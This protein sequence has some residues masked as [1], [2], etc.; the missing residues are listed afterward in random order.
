MIVETASA[1]D[2]AAGAGL[3]LGFLA[4][5][6]AAEMLRRKTRLAPEWTRKLVHVAAGLACLAVPFLIESHWVVLWLALLLSGIFWSAHRTGRL[7]SLHGV[8]RESRG[9]EYYPLVVYVLF[10][11]TRERPWLY[12]C[13]LL[14]LAVSDALAAL[15]GMRYGRLRYEVDGESKS[16]EGSLAF[17][18]A[19]FLVVELPLVLWQDPSLPGPASCVLAALLT[20]ALVTGFEAVSLGGRDNLWVPLGTYLVLSKILRQPFGEIVVQNVGLAVIASA[21]ALSAAWTR[22]FNVGGAIL[23]ALWAFAC[24]SLGSLDWALPMFTSFAAF[25]VL[26]SFT[27]LAPPAKVGIVVRALLPL[28]ALLF[29]ANLSLSTRWGELYPELYG[30]FLAAGVLLLVQ[31]SWNRIGTR[32]HPRGGERQLAVAGVSLASTAIVALPAWLVQENVPARALLVTAAV[33]LACG[34]IHDRVPGFSR[35]SLA[36]GQAGSWF[37]TG[38]TAL[39]VLLFQVLDSSPSWNPE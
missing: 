9:V 39:V 36:P 37:V 26:R 15:I 32:W 13:A 14:T 7:A 21:I 18:V 6:G 20:A 2:L 3:A 19:T 23:F 28:I 22:V 29:A 35:R 1:R 10:V 30:P 11:L 34:T 8:E 16:L 25:L 33:C 27:R 4:L 38:M 24:W 12:V 5:L 31:V 17:L